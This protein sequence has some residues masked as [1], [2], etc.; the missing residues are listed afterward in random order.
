MRP[1][2]AHPVPAPKPEPLAST[3][4]EGAA[5]EA[6]GLLDRLVAE[7]KITLRYVD[8]DG[9]HRPIE[10]ELVVCRLVPRTVHDEEPL[11]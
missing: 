4:E 1:V 6:R 3:S 2:D 8:P 9:H 10:G 7:G 11:P 5:R